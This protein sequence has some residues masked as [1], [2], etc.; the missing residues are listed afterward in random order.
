MKNEMVSTPTVGLALLPILT[1]LVF[2]VVGYGVFGLPIE[3]LLLASAIVASGVAWKLGYSWN[4]IQ[5]AI[6]GV[7]FPIPQ[8]GLEVIWNHITRYRGVDVAMRG[9]QA[10]PTSSGDYTLMEMK[11]SI[12]FKYTKPGMTAKQLN[13]DISETVLWPKLCDRMERYRPFLHYNIT[14]YRVTLRNKLKELQ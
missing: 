11:N 13:E 14:K 1:M 8:S 3:S 5:N 7:P 10:A 4:G 9:S 12:S 2:L 6:M